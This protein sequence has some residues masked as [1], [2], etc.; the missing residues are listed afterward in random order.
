M[1]QEKVYLIHPK[2]ISTTPVRTIER[3]NRIQRRLM[4]LKDRNETD[5]LNSEVTVEY[6]MENLDLY[7]GDIMLTGNQV[8]EIVNG[9]VKQAEEK[10][11]DVSDIESRARKPKRGKRSISSSLNNMWT[12]P[13]PYYVDTGVDELSV[14]IALNGLESETCIRFIKSETPITGKSGLRYYKGGGCSSYIG[15]AYTNAPQEVSIGQGCGSNAI[16]QHETAHALGVYHEQSRPDRYLYVTIKTEDIIA[17]KESN[18]AGSIPG[19]VNEYGIPYDFGSVMHYGRFSFS[20]NGNQTIVAIDGKYDKTMGQR[21]KLSFNDIKL[22]NFKYCNSTCPSTSISCKNGG[23]LDPNNCARCKCPLNF[24]GTYCQ[25]YVTSPSTTCGNQML[26]ANTTLQFLTITGALNC[27]FVINTTPGYVIRLNL[28]STSLVNNDPCFSGKGLEIKHKTD[29][30]ATGIN[31]CGV[32]SYQ[33][34]YS[35]SDS[36]L[37]HYVG[38][39]A[40]DSFTLTYIRY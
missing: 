29:K 4:R 18:F 14:K 22:I 17:G 16:I 37:I 12:F 5:D 39:T 35:E 34:F 27:Y 15:K 24:Y 8:D 31:F 6:P 1:K 40:T 25:N 10:K 19:Y 13:I 9:L 2:K 33:I 20:K 32:N 3:L 11:I 36:V 26:T 28:I 30:T 23:Y 38:T 7:E 21:K